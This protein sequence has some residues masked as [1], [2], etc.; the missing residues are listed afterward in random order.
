MKQIYYVNGKRAS[1]GDYIN[2]SAYNLQLEQ[3]AEL[4]KVKVN[5]FL[6]YLERNPN[7]LSKWNFCDSEKIAVEMAF[8]DFCNSKECKDV[9]DKHNKAQKR[10]AWGCIIVLVVAIILFVLRAS[11]VI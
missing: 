1:Y 4:H 5:A 6:D 2:A 8:K 10:K 7:A 9:V 11:G 3:E